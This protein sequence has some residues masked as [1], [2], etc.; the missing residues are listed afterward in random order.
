VTTAKRLPALPDIPSIGE[1]VPGYDTEVWWG[2]LGPGN[3]PHELVEKL[4]H[5]FVA[6]LNTDTV[7]DRLEK[8]GAIPI[9]STPED[10]DKKI[11]A[12]FDK[13]GPIIKAAGIKAE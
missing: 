12:D 11:H 4:S 5:D 13:W 3:M 7:K 6:A 1:T 2:L 9:G 8:L 10:F